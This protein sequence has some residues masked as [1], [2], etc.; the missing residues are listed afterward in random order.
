[1]TNGPT[2][3]AEPSLNAFWAPADAHDPFSAHGCRPVMTFGTEGDFH[4]PSD[5]D[6]MAHGPDPDSH[7]SERGRPLTGPE[8]EALSD[9]RA[10]ACLAGIKATR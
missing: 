4:K 3:R 10:A 9:A 6:V 1:M 7:R 5:V 8:V 2:K